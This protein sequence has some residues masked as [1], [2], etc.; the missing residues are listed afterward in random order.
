MHSIKKQFWFIGI[1]SGIL[2]IYAELLSLLLLLS[3]EELELNI[4]LFK[5]F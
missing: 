2:I 1:I 5:Y 3:S 4:N